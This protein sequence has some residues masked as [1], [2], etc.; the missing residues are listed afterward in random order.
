MLTNSCNVPSKRAQVQNTRATNVQSIAKGP[1]R[2]D[3]GKHRA[4][5]PARHRVLQRSGHFLSWSSLLEV[6][7]SARRRSRRVCAWVD[8]VATMCSILAGVVAWRLCRLGPQ[9][10]AGAR[11]SQTGAPN[12][13]RGDVVRDTLHV[14]KLVRSIYFRRVLIQL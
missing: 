7:A 3:L 13:R 8:S 6:S 11:R 1:D 5:L 4:S 14:C 12:L 2:V 10:M 9:Q